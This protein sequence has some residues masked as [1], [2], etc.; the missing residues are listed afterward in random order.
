MP[1]DLQKLKEELAQLKEEKE[2]LLQ[3]LAKVE[4]AK[5]EERAELNFHRR[6]W[7]RRYGH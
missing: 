3:K 7:H 2:N 1:E 6:T 5:L 4:R